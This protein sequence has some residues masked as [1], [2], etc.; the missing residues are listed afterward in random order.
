MYSS[1]FAVAVFVELCGGRI[2]FEANM[3][4]LKFSNAHSLLIRDNK[5]NNQ[6]GNRESNNH[7]HDDAAV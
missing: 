3:F 1:P 7:Y 2:D 5:G 6:Q 4:I